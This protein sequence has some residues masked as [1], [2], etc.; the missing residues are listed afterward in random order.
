MA[1]YDDID[2]MDIDPETG[3][4]Y[5]NYSSSSLDTSFHDGEMDCD[6]EDEVLADLRVIE[7]ALLG[8]YGEPV[9][10]ASGQP[11][12]GVDAIKRVRAAIKVREAGDDDEEGCTSHGG[13][14]WV[15][16]DDNEEI[17][18]C[19]YCGADGNA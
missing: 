10:G 19:E 14:S 18:Y 5:S 9:A 1:R 13:H 7:K 11:A 4:P 2:P 6:D 16:R 8:A 17:S 12:I 15:V 3:R